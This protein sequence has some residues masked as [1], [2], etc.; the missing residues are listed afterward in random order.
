MKSRYKIAIIMIVIAIGIFI[1]LPPTMTVILCDDLLLGL[2][3]CGS[4]LEE[5]YLKLPLVQHFKEMYSD[6]PG[7]GFSSDRFNAVGVSASSILADKIF[8]FLEIDLNDSTITYECQ[9]HNLGDE[10]LIV[11]IK[12]PTIEDLDNNDCRTLNQLEDLK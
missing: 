9:N 4:Y 11:K 2:D 7:L 3:D 12:N 10:Y 5:K 6:P 1:V 8:V